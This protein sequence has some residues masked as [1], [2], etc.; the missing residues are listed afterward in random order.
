MPVLRTLTVLA[1]VYVVAA[2]QPSASGAADAVDSCAVG[3][4]SCDEAELE[5]ADSAAAGELR[6]E[7]LQQGLTRHAKAMSGAVVEA[8]ALPKTAAGE[9]TAGAPAPARSDASS[10]ARRDASPAGAAP[11]A[12]VARAAA[13]EKEAL[14]E[15][16][17]SA[18][19]ASA[20]VVPP[21]PPDAVAP[22]E[23]SATVAAAAE[24]AEAV[25]EGQ[26]LAQ[27]HATSVATERLLEKQFPGIL[28]DALKGMDSAMDTAKATAAAL[29]DSALNSTLSTVYQAALAVPTTAAGLRQGMVANA[30]SAAG[31]QQERLANFQLAVDGAADQFNGKWHPVVTSL[32]TLHS[33]VPAALRTAGLSSVADDAEATLGEGD[34]LLGR[35]QAISNELRNLTATLDGVGNSTPEV[36]EQKLLETQKEAQMFVDEAD[37][38]ADTFLDRIANFTDR[39]AE[40]LGVPRGSFSSSQ[41]MASSIV[42]QVLDGVHELASGIEESAPHNDSAAPH[43]GAVAARPLAGFAEG[44][45]ALLALL[46]SGA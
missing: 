25:I 7:L 22:Q 32:Q 43:S 16:A 10:P 5:L 30:Q 24:A 6:V 41:E 14:V 8:A 3:G 36:A 15:P 17:A 29:L 23:V 12:G 27:A 45:A 40:Q 9:P 26:S 19:T 2:V 31:T 28:R 38:F 1:Q 4:R 18:R 37:N 21:P 46:S 35:A 39:A 13:P 33:T 44:C 11:Q 42:E 34:G 20:A